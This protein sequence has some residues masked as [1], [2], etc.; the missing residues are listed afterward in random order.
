M[1]FDRSVSVSGQTYTRKIDY[2]V[3]SILTGIACSANKMAVDIR[4]LQNLKEIEEPFESKQ[5][6]SSAMAYKRNPMRCERICSLSRFVM[7]LV[8]NASNTHANQVKHLKLNSFS[9]LKEHWMVSLSFFNI[10]FCK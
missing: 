2:F 3:L 6:G 5:V 8:D 7:S 1:G 10:R 9:G 4:L